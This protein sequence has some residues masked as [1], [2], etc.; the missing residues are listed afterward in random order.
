M[1]PHCGLAWA[2]LALPFATQELVAAPLKTAVLMLEE[3]TGIL[4][5]WARLSPEY[6]SVRDAAKTALNGLQG[7]LVVDATAFAR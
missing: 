6:A 2:A 3:S 1:V 7:T 4:E 5:S